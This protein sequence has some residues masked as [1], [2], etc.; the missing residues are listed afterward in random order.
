LELANIRSLWEGVT[1]GDSKPDLELHSWLRDRAL[2]ALKFFTF[3]TS[4]PSSDVSS[5][6]EAAFFSCSDA[7]AFSIISTTGV[8]NAADVRLPDPT[9]SGF[10]KQ[11]PVLPDELL[12]E[13][14]QMIAALQTR[15]MIR[16]I[17]WP[18]VLSE[19]RQRP[20]LEEEMIA[21]LKWWIGLH[22]QGNTPELSRIRTELLNAAV[23]VMR[24]PNNS[25]EGILQLNSIE[26]F[27]NTRN[28]G[29]FVPLD[30]GAPLPK[31]LLP[32]SISKHFEATALMSSFPWR[33]LSIVDWLRHVTTPDVA[34]A[35][36]NY[37]ISKS[38]L[39][40]ERV[41]TVLARAWPSLSRDAQNEIA[42]LLKDRTCIPTNRGL[43]LPDGSYFPNANI[44]K[45]LP[46]VTLPSGTIIKGMLEKVFI[47]V[48]VR[49]HVELQIV[50]DR[51]V[52]RRVASR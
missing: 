34:S 44:F 36:I 50:F 6:M 24:T 8:R 32:L 20:L 27:I 23:L 35:D 13:A 40:A 30:G 14:K 16:D 11:L 52:V 48:G 45:D 37:D 39:W 43:K 31:H 19:L 21:C 1:S 28:M 25:E 9:F 42:L 38:S 51:C 22:K 12:T 15:S 4:T 41:F 18:D 47:A 3:H 29:G 17:S 2:H 5:H 7:R 46:I 26:T 10:I 49:K 33:E